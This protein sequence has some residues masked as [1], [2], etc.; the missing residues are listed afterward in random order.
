MPLEVNKNMEELDLFLLNSV[1][2]MSVNPQTIHLV[3][4]LFQILCEE[5]LERAHLSLLPSLL[6]CCL[7]EPQWL[8]RV[9]FYKPDNFHFMATFRLL[10][11][12]TFTR[13]HVSTTVRH[14]TCKKMAKSQL[15]IH[16]PTEAKCGKQIAGTIS[17]IIA[18]KFVSSLW[19]YCLTI[20]SSLWEAKSRIFICLTLLA[21][22]SFE[23]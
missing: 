21:F 11:V 9:W 18:C 2:Q 22:G 6:H 13:G 14:F 1:S 5:L 19:T 4:L 7:S 8:I 3:P 23:K 10:Y 20:L 17:Y 16:V 12:G 15:A